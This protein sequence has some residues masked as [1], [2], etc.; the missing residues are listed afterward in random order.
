MNKDFRRR[1]E[2]RRQNWKEQSFHLSE[3]E[4]LQEQ[5]LAYWRSQSIDTMIMT[6]WRLSVE[7]Y[8]LKQ[9]NNEN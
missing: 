8:A 4:K 6:G 1:A 2:I 3:H 7:Q 9:E 5:D